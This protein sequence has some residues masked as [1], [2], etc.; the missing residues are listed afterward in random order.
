MCYRCDISHTSRLYVEVSK[1]IKMFDKYNCSC[2]VIHWQVI[3]YCVIYIS[4]SGAWNVRSDHGERRVIVFVFLLLLNNSNMYD[5]NSEY[6]ISTH[7]V[8]HIHV[9]IFNV[10]III[11]TEQSCNTLTFQPM[12][13]LKISTV[14]LSYW[15]FIFPFC[16]QGKPLVLMISKHHGLV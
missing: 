11:T 7:N 2:L 4:N 16:C 8:L 13:N 3:C 1:E 9:Y 10:F 14:I 5:L 12:P 15:Y 6:N